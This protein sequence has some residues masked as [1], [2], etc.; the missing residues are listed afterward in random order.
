[1]V[2]E[3]NFDPVLDGGRLRA[4]R[5]NYELLAYKDGSWCVDWRYDVRKLSGKQTTQAQAQAAAILAYKCL[6]RL[7]RGLVAVRHVEE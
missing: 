1:M 5:G 4:F 6:R 3:W 7:H 2:I